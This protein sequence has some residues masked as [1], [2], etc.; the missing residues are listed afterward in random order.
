[1]NSRIVRNTT[2]ALAGLLLLVAV[3]WIVGSSKDGP[4]LPANTPATS[5]KPP[6]AP[7]SP[8]EDVAIDVERS[9][10]DPPPDPIA[11]VTKKREEPSVSSPESA[12]WF[13]GRVISAV[14]E[15][16]I[17]GARILVFD[18]IQ[19]AGLKSAGPGPAAVAETDGSGYFRVPCRIEETTESHITPV[20]PPERTLFDPAEWGIVYEIAADGF[21][22]AL[23]V[24][25]SQ[26]GSERSPWIARLWRTA[27]LE[28]VVR[29]RADLPVLNGTLHVRTDLYEI[30]GDD[31]MR[32]ALIGDGMAEWAAKADPTGTYRLANLPSRVPFEL[33]LRSEKE[34]LFRPPDS[35]GL[36]PG[37]SR[38]IAWSIGAGCTLRGILLDQLDHPV[39]QRLL[40][41]TRRAQAGP[42]GEGFCFYY[43]GDQ[44]KV[45]QSTRTDTTGAFRFDD[46]PAG[47]WWLGPSPSRTNWWEIEPDEARQEV[48]E[49]AAYVKIP[50]D[51]IDHRVTLHVERGLLIRGRVVDFQGEPVKFPCSLR[52]EWRDGHG[53]LQVKSNVECRFTLGPVAAGEYEITAGG[54]HGLADSLPVT[55]K[56]GSE[57]VLLVLRQ[58]GVISGVVIAIGQTQETTLAYYW[59]TRPTADPFF[60]MWSQTDEAGDFSAGGLLPGV[61]DICAATPDGLIGITRGLEVHA[62]EDLRDVRVE[63]IPGAHLRLTY[64]GPFEHAHIRV[65]AGLTTVK[66]DGLHRGTSMIF[67]VPADHELQV[68]WSDDTGKKTETIALRVGETRELSFGSNR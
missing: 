45:V 51:V 49:K 10:A 26:R 42:P 67:T 64:A 52:A 30:G 66:A 22:P 41:L 46:V 31:A 12:E 8:L 40:W 59:I 7:A 33:E 50:A 35:L 11:E 55:A 9:E 60:L 62:G 18:K 34:T 68:R 1:M 21:S 6:A 17:A 15:R 28:V 29:D 13:F 39:A 43:N 38:R 25:D 44:E 3:I 58:G 53:F 47:E 65:T 63:M 36:E 19:L 23:F 27:S 61:Y 37:E 20:A 57:D 54:S 4:S 32:W 56:A 16:P 14:D 24:T 2:W 48:V 5:A